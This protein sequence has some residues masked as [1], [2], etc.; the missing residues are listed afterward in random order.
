VGVLPFFAIIPDVTYVIFTKVMSPTPTDWVLNKQ[1]IDPLKKY[2][3][4]DEIY[5]V[6]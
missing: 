1:K 4:F 2:D 3:G 6:Y 5:A